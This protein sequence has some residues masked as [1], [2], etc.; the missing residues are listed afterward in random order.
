MEGAREARSP[1][2]PAINPELHVPTAR[3]G[4]QT[5]T[6]ST[7]CVVFLGLYW[8]SLL[9][10]L[11]SCSKRALEQGLSSCGTQAYLL[12]GTC[13]LPRSGIEHMSPAL[14]GGFFTPEPP[15]KPQMAGFDGDGRAPAQ[16]RARTVPGR[17]SMVSEGED[18]PCR[19]QI[20]PP[21]LQ[22][23]RRVQERNL[24]PLHTH[25]I[26]HQLHRG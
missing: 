19:P 1:G 17:P 10:G 7:R 26:A 25:S 18:L 2:R 22:E 24:H 14:A 5:C 8:S 15:G 6:A 23:P 3:C 21:F 20:L 12:C 4:L 9:R 11:L 16:C 13:D